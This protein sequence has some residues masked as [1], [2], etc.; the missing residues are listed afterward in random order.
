MFIKK[1]Y[2]QLISDRPGEIRMM[3]NQCIKTIDGVRHRESSRKDKV[4]RKFNSDIIPIP[5]TN[6]NYL[7]GND[8]EI[9]I[10]GNLNQRSITINYE[11]KEILESKPPTRCKIGKTAIK[12]I[13]I[14]PVGNRMNKGNEDA[15]YRRKI[16]MEKMKKLIMFW[17]IIP[18][19]EAK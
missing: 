12:S 9:I 5:V 13:I 17:K 10:K 2:S 7:G 11:G 14:D 15:R 3:K 4:K 8:Y 19:S 18:L 6:N 1:D 16:A